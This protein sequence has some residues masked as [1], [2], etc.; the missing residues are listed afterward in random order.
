MELD[1]MSD[2]YISEII[3]ELRFFDLM[4]EYPNNIT[5]S[6]DD[7]EI[8]EKDLS[9]IAGAIKSSIYRMHGI[10]HPFQEFIDAAY[11]AGA[12]QNQPPE[13]STINKE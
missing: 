4:E 6:K 11:A 12:E 9:F 8:L 7:P 1:E 10:S 5:P 13:T 2:S 3:D